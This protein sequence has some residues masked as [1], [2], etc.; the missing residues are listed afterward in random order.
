[1][2]RNG[3]LYTQGTIEVY[4]HDFPQLADAIAIPHGLY[5]LKLNTGYLTIG[6]SHDTGE[7][8]CDCILAW[9]QAHG[10]TNYP[11]ATSILILCDSGG[12]NNALHY[13]FKEQLQQL[14]DKI[15]IEI[16]IAHYPPYTSKYNPIEHRLFPHVSRACR[17]VIF[18]NTAMVKNFMQKT[19]TSTGL[20]VFVTINA[21][22]YEPGT[23]VSAGFQSNMRIAFDAYLPQWNY[24]AIPSGNAHV[25]AFA[26]LISIQ[27][28]L[29][30]AK[31]TLQRTMQLLKQNFTDTH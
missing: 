26:D 3:W 17:G 19:T 31:A 20:Q 2:F 16:R 21:K 18:R 10:K 24:T 23:K 14:A 25:S 4:D 6:T 12:S 8:A 11:H 15:G 29:E 22:R 5:D 27:D 1:M 13:I 28:N 30:A 9:W 7:F